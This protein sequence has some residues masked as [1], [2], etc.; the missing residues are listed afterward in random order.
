MKVQS[1]PPPSL[2]SSRRH[3]HGILDSAANEKLSTLSFIPTLGKTAKEKRVKRGLTERGEGDT[4]HARHAEGRSDGARGPLT[5]QPKSHRA[6]V[7]AGGRG[8]ARGWMRAREGGVRPVPACSAFAF[9]LSADGPTVPPQCLD[10]GDDMREAERD[11]PA[12]SFPLS[13]VTLAAGP[14]QPFRFCC[15][16]TWID[17]M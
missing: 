11:E 14:R 3:C 2:L 4:R 7:A 1:S 8:R 17:C 16:R 10:H 13:S 9:R 6:R 15:R 5:S 12:L